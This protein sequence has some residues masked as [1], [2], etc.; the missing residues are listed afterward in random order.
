V[1]QPVQVMRLAAIV[2][3]SSFAGGQVSAQE[4]LIRH[5]KVYTLTTESPLENTDVLVRNGAIAAVG[6]GL[7]ASTDATLVDANNHPLTPGL[8]GG[9]SALG[10]AEVPHE[11]SSVDDSQG[12]DS[13]SWEQQWRPEFDVTLAYNPRS[14]VVPI[15]RVEGVTWTVLSASSEDSILGGQGAAITLDGRFDAVLPGSRTLF[16]Q[17]GGGIGK[18]SNGSRAGQYM[19]LD[20]AIREARAGPQVAFGTLLHAAGREALLRYLNGGRMVFYVERAADILG[21]IAFAHRERIRPIVAGGSEAW[22]V[23]A[24]LAHADVP[25]ILDPLEDLPET[26]DQLGARLDNAARLHRAGVQ[27]AFSG[28]YSRG[29]RQLAGNAVAHGLPWNIA[30]AAITRT[31]A[32]IFG[33]GGSRGR[34]AVGQTAD[35]VLWDGDPLEVTTIAERVWIAGRSIALR[36]RQTELRDRYMQ[37]VR[38]H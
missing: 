13:P 12:A 6:S 24:E 36:S 11:S 32:E 3:F 20:Q 29:I 15:T 10:L 27:I 35:L 9:L 5:A 23:A 4:V 8:F 28:G 31:P 7:H 16:V 21:L 22:V 33:L 2:A 18:L 19:L 34:I 30:L 25:V 37:P 14:T 38:W 17:L 1:K 26:F